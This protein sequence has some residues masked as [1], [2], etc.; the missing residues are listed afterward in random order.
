VYEVPVSYR[1]RTYE[2]GKKITWKD[3][4]AALVHIA[5]FNLFPGP[6]GALHKGPP[7]PSLRP[8]PPPAEDD[9]EQDTQ[10]ASS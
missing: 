1:G 10:I 7:G 5:R 9:E 4:V 2:D 8:P 3:G 6:I